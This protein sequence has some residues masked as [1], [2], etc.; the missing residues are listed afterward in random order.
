MQQYVT[1]AWY[2]QTAEFRTPLLAQR[3]LCLSKHLVF[4]IPEPSGRAPAHSLSLSPGVTALHHRPQV[5]LHRSSVAVQSPKSS[6]G[7][8]E[9][10]AESASGDEILHF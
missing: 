2:C 1:A 7:L 8:A 3:S 4:V 10:L 6:V 9:T 5:V